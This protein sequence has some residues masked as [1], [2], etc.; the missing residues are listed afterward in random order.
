VERKLK[1]NLNLCNTG[2]DTVI[3]PFSQDIFMEICE[4]PAALHTLSC[5]C[6]RFVTLIQTASF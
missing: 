5:A 3:F 1:M 4:I 6:F 2:L